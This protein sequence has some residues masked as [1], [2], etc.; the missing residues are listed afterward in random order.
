MS[1]R[2]PNK[3]DRKASTGAAFIVFEQ[4]KEKILSLKLTPATVLPRSE[5]QRQFGVSST[6]IRDALMKLEQISLVDIFPQS[7]T[8]VSLISIQLAR[9]EQFLRRSIELEVV[10]I[11]AS[12]QNRE[13]IPELRASLAEQ[14]EYAKA[15]NFERFNEA[16]LRFHKLMYVGANAGR[17]WDL[18]RRQSGHIDRIR[19][20]HLPI[21]GKTAQIIQDHKGILRAIAER[22]P[23]RAQLLLRDHLSQSLAFSE[24]LR[25]QYP[26]YFSGNDS[27]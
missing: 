15:G 8:R 1:R 18:V 20:M 14:C 12:S 21:R 5:L 23:D 11:L 3:D 25:V 6:P 13:F 17:L 26:S 19:R 27:Y 9:Q 22:D 7:G 24:Q 10:H 16:D 2:T 4:L